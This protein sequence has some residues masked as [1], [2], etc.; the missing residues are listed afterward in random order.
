MKPLKEYLG[1]EDS[2]MN[3]EL[4]KLVIDVENEK[5]REE[6]KRYAEEKLKEVRETEKNDK[7]MEELYIK[8]RY[9]EDVWDIIKDKKDNMINGDT[10]KIAAEEK[11]KEDGILKTILTLI[12]FLVLTTITVGVWLYGV[13][14]IIKAI[15]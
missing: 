10:Y 7:K 5:E 14:N 9:G 4:N 8:K 6:I 1:K 13:W 2:N 3:Q 11:K 15:I 12:W